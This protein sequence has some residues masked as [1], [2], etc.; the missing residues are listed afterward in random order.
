[1]TKPSH[2]SNRIRT[3]LASLL[4]AGSLNLQADSSQADAEPTIETS[5]PPI[6]I[7]T[8]NIEW[9]PGKRRDAH[10]E[11]AAE[12]AALVQRELAAMNPDILLAQE[13]RDWQAFADLCQA[14]PGL[15]PAVVSAFR[16]E[17]SGE[18]WPQ[19]IAIGS[20]LPVLA[21]WS[22]FWREGEIH[23]RRG[24]SAVA[25]Q[26]PQ[27]DQLLLVY[28][29]HLKSNRSSTEEEEQL[30][31]ATRNESIR[32]LL[33]HIREMEEIVFP[34]RILGV[35][36]GGD[37]NTNQDGHFGDQV[38]NMMVEAGFYNTW[39]DTPRSRRQTWRGNFRFRPSTLDHIY[40][41]G[42]GTP[43]AILLDPPEET[44]DHR[45]VKLI[46]PLP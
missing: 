24:F 33:K 35:V 16:S 29:L 10:D 11:R 4:L 9:Y 12:H 46:L 19:Q 41:K 34:G 2:I 21:A 30:N 15:Q 6:T 45:P 38:H 36:V 3:L 43:Q 22:E 1:M 31:F 44:S 27:T 8:W 5:T 17:D 18:Y 28:S 14:V 37:F 13:I 23:P 20:K 26:L 39:G 42:L 7:I 40:V 32:Q 25:L